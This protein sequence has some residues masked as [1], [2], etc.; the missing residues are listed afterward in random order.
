L[1]SL[2]IIIKFAFSLTKANLKQGLSNIFNNE[3]MMLDEM[4]PTSGSAN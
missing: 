3:F 1:P 2:F 4:R